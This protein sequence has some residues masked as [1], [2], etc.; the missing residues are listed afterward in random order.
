MD[1]SDPTF[2][3]SNSALDLGDPIFSGSSACILD[4]N[5]ISRTSVILD[6]GHTGSW[7]D[8]QWT[9]ATLFFPGSNSEKVIKLRKKIGIETLFSQ[10]NFMVL[11]RELL[12][13]FSIVTKIFSNYL[14]GIPALGPWAL[15]FMIRIAQRTKRPRRLHIR[16]ELNIANE[17]YIASRSH[18]VMAR[19]WDLNWI[20][21]TSVN[22]HGRPYFLGFE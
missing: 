21:Q 19:I 3:G 7:R 17:C 15:V 22:G 20:S 14:K 10:P 2:S 11:G 4:L 13:K 6:D 8:S 16:F 9:W 5:W 12:P 18:K 1:L